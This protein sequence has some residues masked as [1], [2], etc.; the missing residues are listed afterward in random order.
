MSGTC[1]ALAASCSQAPW[2]SRGDRVLQTGGTW[3]AQHTAR[4]RQGWDQDRGPRG[5]GRPSLLPT[6]S[7]PQETL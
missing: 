2:R 4:Q 3:K 7:V 5:P 1:H 6:L